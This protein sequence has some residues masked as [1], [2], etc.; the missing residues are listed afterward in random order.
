M[1]VSDVDRHL[2][3]K[4]RLNIRKYGNAI[5]DQKLSIDFAVLM[6]IT[7]HDEYIHQVQLYPLKLRSQLT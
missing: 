2:R 5:F 1:F 7:G 4:D 3:I 6:D